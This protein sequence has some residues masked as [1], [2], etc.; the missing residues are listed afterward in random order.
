MKLYVGNLSFQITE[1]DLRELFAQHGTVTDAVLMMDRDTQRPRGFGFVTMSSS[2][3][4]QRAID[5]LNGQP[6]DGRDLT[7]NEARPMEPRGPRREFSGGGGGRSGGGG[8]GGRS[9]GNNR[10]RY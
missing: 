10:N 6:H 3:E 5:A 4:G 7:V 9:G 2:E 1:R 8:G